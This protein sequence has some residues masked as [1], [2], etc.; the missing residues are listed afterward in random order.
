M[1][2]P[3]SFCI[4]ALAVTQFALPAQGWPEIEFTEVMVDPIG[5]NTNHQKIE[6][7][8]ARNAP[9]NFT[10]WHLVSTAG[11]FA[12]PAITMQPYG[13]AVLH[14]G[15]TGT[16]T[17]TDIY[18][19]SMPGLLGQDTLALF[20]SAQTTNAADL[21][22]F[23]AWGGGQTSMVVAIQA[24][25]WS[26][27]AASVTLPATEGASIAHYDDVSYGSRN[28][29][30]AWFADGTPTIGD[31]NDGGGI[32]GGA[33]GC[34]GPTQMPALGSGAED[35]RPWLGEPWLLTVY[36]LPPTPSLMFVAIGTQPLGSLP[37]GQFGLTNCWFEVN[38][39]AI[40]ATQMPP[41]SGV[42][43]LAL[44]TDPAFASF[45]LLL[46]ALV[47]YP[48][49]NPANMMATRVTHAHLGSR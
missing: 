9:I 35:N 12:L 26:F 27:P 47:T 36:D 17:A 39:Y 38:P 1:T 49:A 22:D 42:L 21:E 46:Q 23:V 44:P 32:F 34:Y 19:P 18:L 3:L 25:Q 10:G 11:T 13:L 5:P 4:T 7:R 40:L 6:L 14:L 48:G 45:E 43:G 28:R 8:N 31:I 41:D 37:L 29:P 33:H 20:R 16:T 2:K 30:E 24:T 15:Q